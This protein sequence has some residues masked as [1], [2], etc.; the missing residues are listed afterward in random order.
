MLPQT[1]KFTDLV[2]HATAHING[3]D[4]AAI[5]LETRIKQEIATVKDNNGTVE[6]VVTTCVN[7]LGLP[8][9][10]AIEFVSFYWDKIDAESVS[11]KQRRATGTVKLGATNKQGM[12]REKIAAANY[13]LETQASVVDW[14]VQELG[15]SKTL[16]KQYVSNLWGKV[17]P[18]VNGD[19]RRH[20]MAR[21]DIDNY[22]RTEI[23][24]AKRE[25]RDAQS[26]AVIVSDITGHEV[27]DMKKFAESLWDWVV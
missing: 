19:T 14:A 17:T 5:A 23:F 11:I 22:I 20:C 6:D 16:A 7:S 21:K 25:G 26:V 4:A 10:F 2:A 9:D 1:N 15:M 24:F 18:E 8:E 13:A 12:L 3:T 27:C